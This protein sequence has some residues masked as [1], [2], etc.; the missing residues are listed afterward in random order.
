M[1]HLNSLS[2]FMSERQGDFDKMVPYYTPYSTS[3]YTYMP[4]KSN[5]KTNTE[6]GAYS[7]D[8][9]EPRYSKLYKAYFRFFNTNIDHRAKIM[10]NTLPYLD[11]NNLSRHKVRNPQHYN[12]SQNF[13]K[14][15]D[16]AT[17]KAPSADFFP[18]KSNESRR[19]KEITT[20]AQARKLKK[21]EST[22][23]NNLFRAETAAALHH[24]MEKEFSGKKITKKE[25]KKL[26]KKLT[27]SFSSK[28]K[29]IKF[30]KSE[31]PN[32]DKEQSQRIQ[33]GNWLEDRV[34]W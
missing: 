1:Y 6:L 12:Y 28:G 7:Y 13:D 19:L 9:N 21:E 23:Y 29:I 3:M 34:N 33:E 2:P 32:D 30:I 18:Y 5:H 22:Y 11:L 24:E 15:S 8:P 16:S 25:K 14:L 4:T 27:K 20:K 31:F 10:N 26:L 17:L